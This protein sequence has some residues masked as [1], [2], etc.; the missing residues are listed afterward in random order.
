[1]TKK[2]SIKGLYIYTN[3]FERGRDSEQPDAQSDAKCRNMPNSTNS[4]Q[5]TK[6]TQEKRRKIISII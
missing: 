3:V 2:D 4:G 5:K 6:E 1:M